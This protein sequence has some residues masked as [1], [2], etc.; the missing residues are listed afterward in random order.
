MVANY[1]RIVAS[2]LSIA[3]YLLLTQKHTLLGVVTN[4]ICQILLVPFTIKNKAW[5]MTA[6]SAFFGGLNI[7][8]ILTEL[9]F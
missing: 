4:L 7:H 6:L 5:D 2:I 8:I 9:I 1:F 3:S